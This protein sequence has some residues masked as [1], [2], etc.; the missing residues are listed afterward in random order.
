ME[1]LPSAR[2]KAFIKKLVDKKDRREDLDREER[3]IKWKD[4]KKQVTAK[5]KKTVITVPKAIKRRIKVGEVI[6][7]GELAKKMGVKASE[8]INKLIGL[9]LMVTINQAI[10]CDAATLIA[11]E[12]GYQVE[13]V[14]TEYDESLQ[15]VDAVFR[16]PESEGARCYHNGT[17]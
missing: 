8:V 1:E 14:G 10:E 6:T 17:C 15:K 13:S 5:M 2:K 16:K 12:F 9:G 3:I 4:G 11:G 7:V